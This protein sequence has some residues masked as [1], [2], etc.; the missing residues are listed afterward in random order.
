MSSSVVPLPRPLCLSWMLSRHSV[1]SHHDE[2]LMVKVRLP[3]TPTRCSALLLRS[4]AR[5][6]VS[7]EVSAG[8]VPMGVGADYQL[9]ALDAHHTLAVRRICPFKKDACAWQLRH[10][11]TAAARG[12]PGKVL[13]ACC[14]FRADAVC[15]V[16]HDCAVQ[17]SDL[18]FYGVVTH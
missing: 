3:Y 7:S 5:L 15:D 2:G 17:Y 18:L 13:L 6:G 9:G 10:R 12:A 14:D 11:V 8:L 1:A 16:W 4:C